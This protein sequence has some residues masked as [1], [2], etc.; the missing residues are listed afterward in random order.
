METTLVQES[1]ERRQRAAKHLL[2]TSSLEGQ[3]DLDNLR[4]EA[5]CEKEFELEEMQ[6]L[7]GVYKAILGHHSQVKLDD[8]LFL[9]STID[10]ES[11]LQA[12]KMA[13]SLDE[14]TV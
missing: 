5:L 3:I 14:V 6:I 10:R 7:F 12:L 2:M 8:V 4:E 11:A 9:L 1:L 13:Y